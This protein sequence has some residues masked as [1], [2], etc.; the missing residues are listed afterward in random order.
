MLSLP[1][2]TTNNGIAYVISHL[3]RGTQMT[4]RDSNKIEVHKFSNSKSHII[5]D[6]CMK[7]YT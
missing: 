2:T 3:I 7:S 4:R 6:N 5:V 1:I